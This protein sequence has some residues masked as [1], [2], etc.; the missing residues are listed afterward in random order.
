MGN[1]WSTLMVRNSLIKARLKISDDIK[2]LGRSKAL[3]NLPSPPGKAVLSLS[4]GRGDRCVSA[5][6][7]LAP[8]SLNI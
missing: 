3:P 7:P 1:T 6:V 8:P 5:A 2:V 4:E